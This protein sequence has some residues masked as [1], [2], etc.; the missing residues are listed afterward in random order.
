MQR[1]K[2]DRQAVIAPQAVVCGDVTV[3]KDSSI[4]YPAVV[5]GDVQSVV[6]G[7]GTNIQDG[8]VLHVDRDYPL[9]IGDKVTVGH[10][11]ILH[12]CTVADQVLIGMGA[13]VRNGA[14]I[15]KNS[16]VAA[17]TLVTQNTVVPEGSLVMEFLFHIALR[18]F[19]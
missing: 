10:G 16:M 2:I 7:E 11:A 5:R 19:L 18:I 4:W 6:I 12:D 1:P 13:I 3:G 17:G 8:A 15:G 9:Q 14:V